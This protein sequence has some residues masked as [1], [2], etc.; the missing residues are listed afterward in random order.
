MSGERSRKRPVDSREVADATNGGHAPE[1]MS[2][3]TT[4]STWSW[5]ATCSA[6]TNARA[7]GVTDARRR[8]RG[9]ERRRHAIGLCRTEAAW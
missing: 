1:H 6:T 5:T 4:T 3:S 2:P 9:R 8:G 7:F